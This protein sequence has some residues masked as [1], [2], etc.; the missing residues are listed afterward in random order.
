M[1]KEKHLIS[2][3]IGKKESIKH[4][5]YKTITKDEEEKVER[6]KF[7]MMMDL[8]LEINLN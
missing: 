4:K 1:K 7:C 5:A 3:A 8:I 2:F 6:N